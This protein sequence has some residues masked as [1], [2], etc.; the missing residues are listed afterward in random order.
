MTSLLPIIL[1][2]D[3]L[4][5][6]HRHL[7]SLVN[8]AV[9]SGV[10]FQDIEYLPEQGPVD[11]LFKIDF[12]GKLK[13][14]EYIIRN[15]KD[16]DMLFV[17][18]ALKSSWLLN[19][20]EII[21]P[22]Y[23]EDVLFPEMISPAVTKMRHWIS[24][25]LRDQAACQEFYHYYKEKE[26]RFAIKFLSHC[27]KG[28]I[29]EEV[30][31]ILTKLS[32]HDFKVLCEK[33]PQVAKIYFDSLTTDEEVRS[34]YLRQEKAFYNSVKCVLKSDSDMFLDIMEKYFNVNTFP[35][36]SPLATDYLLRYHKNRFTSKLELYVA[37][38]LHIPTLAA[39]L[40]VEECQEVV[41]QLARAKYLQHWFE[42]KVVEPFVK[43]L[44]PD[45]RAVFKKRV[46]VE[47]DI[48]KCVEEWPYA[49]PKPP[50][51]IDSNPHLFDEEK[52]EPIYGLEMGDF[53]YM[54][55]K[56]KFCRYEGSRIVTSV[57]TDLDRLFDE[58]RFIGF[59]RALHDLGQRLVR[60]GSS[61]RRRDIFLVLVSKSGGRNDA[62]AA[63]LK[64]ASRH[65]NEPP[66]IRA[67]ILRSLVKRTNVWRLPA[68]VWQN[69]L[70]FGHGLGFDGAPAE[71][72]CTEGLHA[73][74]IRH[75][76]S[77]ESKN[78]VCATF[79]KNFSPLAEYALKANERTLISRGL[80]DM[81]IAAAA[82]SE[83]T[84][85]AERIS[86]LLD[87]IDIYH[88][89]VK[90]ESPILE[91]VK[92]LVLQDANVAK[93]LLER[94]YK[95]GIGRRELFRVNLKFRC[96]QE[97]CLNALRHDP[98]ALD[99]AMLADIVT[100][101]ES[102]F[103]SFFC[104]LG[105]Y[106][107]QDEDFTVHLKSLL[108]EK[109]ISIKNTNCKHATL[110]RSVARL[111]YNQFETEL[112]K[113]DAEG[114]DQS[115]FAARLRACA[116]IARPRINLLQWGWRK[117]GVKAI[118]TQAM[119]SRRVDR[120][121][122]IRFLASEKRTVRVAVA[123][124]IRSESELLL[125]TLASAAK[126]HPVVAL[127]T[128]LSY[129]RHFGT[130][131]NPKVW[132][133]IKPLVSSVDLSSRERLR[134]LLVKTEWIPVS[135]KPDY[136]ATLYLV[137]DKISNSISAQL[138]SD[139]CMMLPKINEDI[140]ENILLHLLQ[141]TPTDADDIPL[142]F[143]AIFIRYLMLP[144][145]N[146][147]LDKRFAKIGG[148]FF[149]RLDSLRS[150]GDKHI[151][152]RLEQIKENLK[153]NAA[154]IDTKY[155]LCPLVIERILAWI[156]TFMPKEEYFDNYAEIHLT[157]LYFKAVRQTMK[158][159]PEVFLDLQKQKVECAEAVGFV[160]GRY[161]SKEV[162]NLVSAFFDSIIELYAGALV[163]YLQV[164]FVIGTVRAKFIESVIKGLWEESVG[165]QRRLAVYV[166]KEHQHSMNEN[167][168]K[169]IQAVMENDE[170]VHLIAFAVV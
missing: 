74:V 71:A 82:H 127:R 8:K 101:S 2:G 141:K 139:L 122:I 13:N 94:F 97:A 24:L 62:V 9:D 18:R 55:K 98:S 63:L 113:L 45:K 151:R 106:F 36:F 32:S 114:D 68:D 161:I 86:Q 170:D 7:N 79:L 146:K 96:D 81:L 50:P 88:V 158:Q 103:D 148:A 105:V 33:C 76:L 164:Y 19:S 116:R 78:N 72:E 93:P 165:L 133:C 65:Q 104:K 126:L 138:L 59:E 51:P 15:L 66:H 4:G 129:F 64:L 153:Y 46:F 110:A 14:V 56:R 128:A 160:F 37:H 49:T 27:K 159:V 152:V 107:N 42:Y 119:L 31:K 163:N 169:E 118:A 77:G 131:S 87:I 147:D 44:S 52:C 67:S 41:L 121:G 120:A 124:C 142:S 162:A 23:L 155:E 95:A 22:K 137:I 90:A 149:E 25:N 61:E 16:D 100:N 83:T 92:N 80:Q 117:A 166:F 21:N 28:F 108:N 111:W 54:L 99:I 58:F 53:R 91:I 123:L 156:Q 3:H 115:K 134:Q 144:K 75:L 38:F 154:F 73:V 57:K 84:V 136:C 11:R 167:A 40:T 29:L 140:I 85:T 157:M 130:N 145:N 132:D 26:F 135:I 35:R 89:P 17:S 1:T 12:A 39:R 10:S 47:K 125:E 6:R 102:R 20:R 150:T 109:I 112:C 48:G 34:C 5:Q 70:D 143:P 30:P 60:A 69:F 168:R 43:R